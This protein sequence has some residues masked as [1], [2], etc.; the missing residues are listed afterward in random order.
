MIKNQ[1]K[2]LKMPI[3]SLWKIQSKDLVLGVDEAWRGAWAGPVVA[4]CVAWQGKN[5][6]WWVLR[7]SK[8]MSPSQREKTYEEI[9]ELAK[10][11][12]LFYGI[13]I[14]ENTMIDEVGIREANRR[15]MEMAL[16]E[17]QKTKYK[18]LKGWFFLLFIDW[19]DNYTFDISDLPQ[20]EYIVRWDAKIK[21]IMAAS[22][23]AK[24]TRDHLMTQYSGKFPEYHWNKN[25]WYGT[26][27]HQ[28][29]LE[30][31]WVS[32]LHRKSYQPIKLATSGKGL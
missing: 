2:T 29:A 13:G 23:L 8:K 20:P 32:V 30:K 10:N 11:W 9:L 17:M 31:I 4:T 27:D 24:V 3:F 28:H 6:I 1:Y 16:Q 21:Q 22:I 18:V 7:D 25:K 19:R 14:I 5:P 26:K 15:A 12:K